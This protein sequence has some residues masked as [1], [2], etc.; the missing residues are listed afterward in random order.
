[1]SLLRIRSGP[2]TGLTIEKNQLA[3][4]LVMALAL[5]VFRSVLSVGPA[6]LIN[7][8]FGHGPILAEMLLVTL[9][10]HDIVDFALD[11]RWQLRTRFRQ[12]GPGVRNF[13]IYK[14]VSEAEDKRYSHKK[15]TYAYLL[16]VLAGCLVVAC[17]GFSATWRT[18][19]VTAPLVYLAEYAAALMHAGTHLSLTS[20]RRIGEG[21]GWGSEKA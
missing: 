17:L 16:G 2:W 4:R 1:M 6:L 8:F 21:P 10:M 12:P 3:D 9:G 15:S 20:E 5:T 19:A 7:Y 18:V 13:S 14:T 11:A